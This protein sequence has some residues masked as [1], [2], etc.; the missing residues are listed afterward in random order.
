MKI[1]I[2]IPG[3]IPDNTQRENIRQ[4]NT[5][6]DTTSHTAHT[7]L[8]PKSRYLYQFLLTLSHY[9]GLCH[10]V[11]VQKTLS[12]L[13]SVHTAEFSEHDTEDAPTIIVAVLKIAYHLLYPQSMKYHTIDNMAELWEKW[14]CLHKATTP[15]VIRLTMKVS[16]TRE[17][18]HDMKYEGVATNGRVIYTCNTN[19]RVC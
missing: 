18:E 1:T 6:T 15:E 12:S 8:S 2:H 5:I 13:I 14:Q 7:M 3:T 11:I 4:G 9:H 16:K 17:L 10:K 19:S